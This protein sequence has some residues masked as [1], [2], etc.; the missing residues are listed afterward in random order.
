MCNNPV[1][2][3]FSINMDKESIHKHRYSFRLSLNLAFCMHAL[4]HV[5]SELKAFQ[6]KSYT[7]HLELLFFCL[8]F[9][10]R[11]KKVR[12]TTP[13]TPSPRFSPF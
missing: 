3:N 2:S 6:V 13:S 5:I 4:L 8:I 12:G 7:V 9:F 10:L 11:K 1:L